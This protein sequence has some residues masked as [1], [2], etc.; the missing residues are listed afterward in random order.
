MA[1]QFMRFATREEIGGHLALHILGV[2]RPETAVPAVGERRNTILVNDVKSCA[3]YAAQF[4]RTGPK[5]GPPRQPGVE[6]II[7]GPPPHGSAEK[8]PEPVENAYFEC[9]L[10]WMMVVIGPH[11]RIAAAVIH[12]DESSSHMHVLFAP[13]TKLADGELRRGITALKPYMAQGQGTGKA[14]MSVIQ[15]RFHRE[16]AVKYGLERGKKGSGAKHK[17]VDRAIALERRTE[18]AKAEAAKAEAARKAEEEKAAQVRAELAASEEAARAALQEAE[19]KRLAACAEAKKKRAEAEA[20]AKHTQ[21]EADREARRKVSEAKAKGEADAERLVADAKEA[22]RLGLLGG[23]VKRGVELSDALE[24]EK[25]AREAAE[26]KAARESAEHDRTH[27]VMVQAL[28]EVD[29]WR[30]AA[31][32]PGRHAKAVIDAGEARQ[33]MDAQCEAAA[34]R[35]RVEGRKEGREE[36]R[37]TFAA[38]LL[39]RGRQLVQGDAYAFLARLV[40]QVLEGGAQAVRGGEAKRGR[41]E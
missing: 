1:M 15:D 30:M 22:G 33:R 25:A 4:P 32:A 20:Q 28:G 19:A 8:W 38:A 11:S 35:A 24:R 37:E 21:A 34:K 36:G 41:G 18:V 17:R 23:A 10:A 5:G 16:V 12:R 3:A 31:H 40:R 26:A 29:A 6:A 13:V 14:Q 2:I 27:A 7:A 39:A 9:A